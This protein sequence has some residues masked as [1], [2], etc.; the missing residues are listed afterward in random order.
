MLISFLELIVNSRITCA[1]LL[2]NRFARDERETYVSNV[3]LLSI[4]R[5]WRICFLAV[6]L[7]KNGQESF[8]TSGTQERVIDGEY[9]LLRRCHPLIVREYRP[10][11]PDHIRPR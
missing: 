9:V 10:R 3:D 2:L 1:L 6:L 5:I 8:E 4:V 7:K 11:D